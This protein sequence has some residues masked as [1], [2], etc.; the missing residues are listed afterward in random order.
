MHPT[1]QY[2]LENQPDETEKTLVDL[3]QGRRQENQITSYF[4][5]PKQNKNTKQQRNK[6]KQQNKHITAKQTKTEDEQKEKQNRKTKQNTTPP[7]PQKEEE[8][9]ISVPDIIVLKL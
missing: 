5:L 2:E 1:K 3:T 7:T 8:K 4:I 9:N 6:Q